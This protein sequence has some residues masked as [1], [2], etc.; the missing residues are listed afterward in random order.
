MKEQGS[1]TDQVQPL[2]TNKI[3]RQRDQWWE[4][5]KEFISLRLMS[6]RQ[7]PQYREI[8]PCLSKDN[9]GQRSVGVCRWAVKVRSITVLGSIMDGVLLAQDGSYT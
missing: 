5:E 2:A 9:V 1:H 4:K 8:L 6:R 7:P 3:Q